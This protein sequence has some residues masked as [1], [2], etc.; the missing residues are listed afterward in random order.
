MFAVGPLERGG[1]RGL[2]ELGTS[3]VSM[4]FPEFLL[5]G[6]N[7]SASVAETEISSSLA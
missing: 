5:E 6:V 1:Y 3:R 2:I 4:G 7:G